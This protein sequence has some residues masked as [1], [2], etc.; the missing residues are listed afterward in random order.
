MNV[1][2]LMDMWPPLRWTHAA[3]IAPEEHTAATYPAAHQQRRYSR[4]YEGDCTR[5][6]WT[7]W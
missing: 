3:H 7:M 4:K 6:S 2:R 1:K 5:A